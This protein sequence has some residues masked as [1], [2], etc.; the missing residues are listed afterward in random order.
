MT[1]RV[2]QR[3]TCCDVGRLKQKH[4]W[5]NWKF[6][7]KLSREAAHRSKKDTHSTGSWTLGYGGFSKLMEWNRCREFE[8]PSAVCWIVTAVPFLN[9]LVQQCCHQTAYFKKKP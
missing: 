1:K 4:S 7:S 6:D 2:G 3:A 8:M 9:L 5:H